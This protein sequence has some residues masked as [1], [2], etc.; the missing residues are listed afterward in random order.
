MQATID[1][2]ILPE[3]S[4]EVSETERDCEF[5]DGPRHRHEVSALPA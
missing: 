5:I 3:V 1:S 2:R 4:G